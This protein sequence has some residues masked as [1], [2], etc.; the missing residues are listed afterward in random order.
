MEIFDPPYSYKEGSA[1]LIRLIAFDRIG[2]I[3]A[4]QKEDCI[5]IIRGRQEFDDDT[6]EDAVRRE[7]KEQA[8]I[9][10]GEVSLAAKIRLPEWINTK[11]IYELVFA[12]LVDEIGLCPNG[13]GYDRFFIGKQ[14]FLKKCQSSTE[15]MKTLVH[16]A[17]AC[18]SPCFIYQKTIPEN[19][20]L[21]FR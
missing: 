21:A 3:L 14:A 7:A 11:P 4:V 5:D 18:C 17:E 10:L 8:N 2:R 16:M 13:R 15:E 12:A 9:S 20:Q 1:R 6:H 19:R